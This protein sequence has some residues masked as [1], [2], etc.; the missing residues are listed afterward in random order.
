[1][2]KIDPSRKTGKHNW[3]LYA[4]A[5]LSIHFLGLILLLAGAGE[6]PQLLGMGFLTYTLGLR[7]AFDIDH[8][9]AIDNS[10]R[11]LLQQ[12][13]DP[14]GIGFFFSL[15]HSSVVFLMTLFSMF[16]IQYAQRVIP[17]LKEVGSII[18]TTVSGGV[19]LFLGVVN[20]YIWN[21][22]Y[23]TFT[24]MRR[25]EYNEE[26]L[27]QLLQNRG[28]IACLIS[29]LYRFINKGWKLFPV[30]FLF[31]LGFDTASEVALLAISIG[32]AR[33]TVPFTVILSFPILFAAGMSLL[34]TA[35]GILM[36]NAYKWA[37]TSPLRKIYYNLTITGISVVVAL[38][39]GFV[40]ITQAVT[41]KIG[42]K[43]WG[44]GWNWNWLQSLDLNQFGY[45]LVGLFVLI[46]MFS[47]LLWKLFGLE[48]QRT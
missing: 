20:L 23:R 15:G 43:G 46:W 47:L 39:I 3:L 27:E 21:D 29:P 22:I 12:R 36:C 31:G 37:F 26:R 16:A 17:E 44:W 13:E 45:I 41:P 18:G 7:H 9:V 40:E 2:N 14:T 42:L 33:D 34:D 35:D 19:L 28:F 4:F 8:I 38:L 25:G 10:V 30:G 32:A 24:A 6:H 5:V 11:K 1:M 48:G